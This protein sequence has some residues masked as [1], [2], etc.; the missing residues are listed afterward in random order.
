MKRV[1]VFLTIVSMIIL[2]GCGSKE[3][4]GKT[5]VR[6]GWW[7]GSS[8]HEA[9]L[10]AI[11]LFEKKYPDIEVKAEYS[12]WSG[13]NDK[14]TTQ[15]VGRSAPDLMQVNWNMLYALGGKNFKDLKEVPEID[16]N[17]YDQQILDKVT[18]DGRVIAIPYGIAGKVFYFNK[19]TYEKAGLDVPKSFDD[20][21][22][23]AKVMKEKLG[24]DYY[25]MDT[26]A[27]GAF[28]LSLYYAEQKTGKPFIEGN[29]VAYTES[30]LTEALSFYTKMVKEGV[31]P[32]LKTRAAA[33]FVTLDQHPDWINGKY[34]GT[35]EWDSAAGKWIGSLKEGQEL[36]LGGL[37]TD[38]GSYKAA[39]NKIGMTFAIN[40]ESKHADAAAKLLNFLLTDPEAVEA[41][42]T[43]RGVPAN[44]A[45]IEILKSKGQLSG[46]I[47][48]GNN[49]VKEFM[50][51]G[52]HPSFE[53]GELMKT[54]ASVLEQMGNGLITEKEA[55]KKLIDEVNSFLANN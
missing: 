34:A 23:A 42:G 21:F 55:A 19:T 41:L 38:I 24:N 51:K 20:L 17:N 44:K 54:Y 18:I 33:G 49:Q 9:T 30:E 5:V 29:K 13:Y 45:A 2:T 40:N 25:P 12:G 46:L 50:G 37:P 47:F 48:E 16:L 15:I 22:K 4:S 53:H 28:L 1:L 31:V 32:S 7:G 3:D 6:F 26:D 14:L 35:Y 36:V 43:T 10:K 8:R 39:F 52:I 11:E 27:Y